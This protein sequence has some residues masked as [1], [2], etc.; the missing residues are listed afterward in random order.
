MTR[1]FKFVAAVLAIVLLASSL[2]AFGVCLRGHATAIHKCCGPHCPMMMKT[3]P[4]GSEFQATLTGASCCKVSSGK[5]IPAS[6]SLEPS[7]RSHIAPLFMVVEPI[8]SALLVPKTKS[9]D[10]AP[11]FRN[12]PPR[13]VLC[14][15][16]I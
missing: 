1:G 5:P 14:I 15:F 8:A 13:S 7:Y 16:L 12:S 2:S 9:L 6:V 3:Q 4:T 11:P 10:E